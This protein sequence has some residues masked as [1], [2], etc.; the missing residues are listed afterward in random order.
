ML[1]IGIDTLS[2]VARCISKDAVVVLLEMKAAR[3]AKPRVPLKWLTAMKTS[4][5]GSSEFLCQQ[6]SL[7]SHEEIIDCG[8]PRAPYLVWDGDFVFRRRPKKQTLTFQV[9]P[10]AIG[11]VSLA[12][13]VSTAVNVYTLDCHP[14]ILMNEI[15]PDVAVQPI[16]C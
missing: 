7:S 11:M 9:V 3:R 4:D 1:G 2:Q 12:S 5:D 8:L 6:V 16:D 15:K 14:R 10:V 13:A